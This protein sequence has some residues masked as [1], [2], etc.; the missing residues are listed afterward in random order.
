MLALLWKKSRQARAGIRDDQV[1]YRVFM[2]APLRP[3]LT[4]YLIVFAG[5]LSFT[6]YIGSRMLMS[7]FALELGASALGAAPVFVTNA[8][9]TAGGAWLSARRR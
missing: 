5:L 1:E 7:L 6:N 4:I 3:R 9:L 2:P 8:I